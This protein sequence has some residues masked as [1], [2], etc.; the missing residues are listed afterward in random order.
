MSKLL[1]DAAPPVFGAPPVSGGTSGLPTAVSGG[2]VASMGGPCA[3][4]DPTK[5]P[6]FTDKPL[7]GDVN[8]G[9]SPADCPTD[10][11]APAKPAAAKAPAAAQPSPAA[12]GKPNAAATPAVPPAP[13]PGKQAAAS[14]PPPP[15][16]LPAPLIDPPQGL[17]PTAAPSPAPEL[18]AAPQ[19][20]TPRRQAALAPD[21]AGQKA[22]NLANPPPANIAAAPRINSP[23]RSAAQEGHKAAPLVNQPPAPSLLPPSQ[24]AKAPAPANQAPAV[25]MLPALQGHQAAALADQA[26]VVSPQPRY[27]PAPAA[28]APVHAAPVFSLSTGARPPAPAPSNALSNQH[29]PTRQ[30]SAPHQAREGIIRDP[31]GSF[32]SSA[33]TPGASRSNAPRIPGA[34]RQQVAHAPVSGYQPRTARTTAS[35]QQLARAPVSG[36][37]PRTNSN[38][39]IPTTGRARPGQ[40]ISTAH[41]GCISTP[42]RARTSQRIPAAHLRAAASFDAAGASCPA[43]VLREPRCPAARVSRCESRRRSIPEEIESKVSGRRYSAGC[44]CGLQFDDDA[45]LGGVQKIGMPRTVRR[46]RANFTS[47]LQLAGAI[48]F[49]LGISPALPA[50]YCDRRVRGCLPGLRDSGDGPA[51]FGAERAAWT[52]QN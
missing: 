27:A 25:P 28:A 11:V 41:R 49:A 39:R 31:P 52:R 38:E 5:G 44:H 17:A 6:F 7:T 24:V 18:L 43:D 29:T 37:Q 12:E 34:S 9:F 16:L 14:A 46:G 33:P 4:R 36:Y 30:A 50:S 23:Q 19:I 20:D 40:R 32:A 8:A 10:P 15:P 3:G 21:D 22:S 51:S 45:A 13:A 35:Q 26:P 1:N 2:P 47:C 48:S 42:G